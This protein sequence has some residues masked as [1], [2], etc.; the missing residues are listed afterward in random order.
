MAA[1]R[2]DQERRT[3]GF[4]TT[5]NIINGGIECGQSTTQPKTEY[6]YGYYRYFCSYF[7]VNPGKNITC[8]K[9]IW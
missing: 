2:K 9:T 3:P 1:Y 6:R 4:G 7:G 8:S 5:V